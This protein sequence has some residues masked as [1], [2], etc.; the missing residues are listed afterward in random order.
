MITNLATYAKKSTHASQKIKNLKV[1]YA[2]NK[3]NL[4]PIIFGIGTNIPLKHLQIVFINLVSQKIDPVVSD[5]PS[6][7][8]K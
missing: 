6:P 1:H 8:Q 4:K 2:T 5:L 7:T 3:Y